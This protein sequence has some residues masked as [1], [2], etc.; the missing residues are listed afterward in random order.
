MD[1]IMRYIISTLF[2]LLIALYAIFGVYRT[3]VG[4]DVVIALFIMLPFFAL[5]WRESVSYFF[6]KVLSDQ[7]SD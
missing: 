5:G 2:P 3:G 7:S 1:T 6:D 4:N